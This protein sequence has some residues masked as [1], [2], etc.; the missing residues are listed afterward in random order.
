MLVTKDLS[1]L[2]KKAEAGRRAERRMKRSK[3]L[4]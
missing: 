2:E 1:D 3:N 4:F